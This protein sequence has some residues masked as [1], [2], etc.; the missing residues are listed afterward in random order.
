M[1]E[2]DTIHSAAGRIRAALV[3]RPI[4]SIAPWKLSPFTQSPTRKGWSTAI[5]RLPKKCS[6]VFCAPSATAIPPMPSPAS[7]VPTG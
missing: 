1:P 3:G 7:N 5:D 6:S 4:V 2:G